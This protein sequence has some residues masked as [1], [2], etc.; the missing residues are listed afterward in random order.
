[1]KILFV[2]SNRLGDAVLSTGLLDH[3]IR[4][5][6]HCQ[7]TVVCGPV[8][9]GLFTHMP[10]REETIVLAKQPWGR[11][12]L[13][14]WMRVMET[15]WDL[16]IDIRGSAL[17][18]LLRT[19]QRAVFRG[20]KGPKVA[21]LGAML[22]LSPAPVPVVWLS[23]MDRRHMEIT[24]MTEQPIV[25]LAPTANWEPKV[26]PAERFAWFFHQ[27]GIQDALPVVVGGPGLAERTMAQQ[28]LEL[29]PEAMDLVGKLSLSEVVALLER[30]TL[31]VGNDSG[32]M[33][34][35]AATGTPTIGLFGPTDAATYGPTGR[36]ATAVIGPSMQAIHVHQVLE[37]A[38]WL[39]A[40]AR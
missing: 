1:M 33:H 25:V 17:A 40:D 26:W 9:E 27:L 24:L 2:T 6:P 4:T 20:G 23:G 37:A 5:N 35:A 18:Y 31:F 21:Q 28:L 38:Q 29:L 22:G 15:R 19:G 34:L 3:L 14:L 16:V 7:I 32:L 30:A 12:W 11:H 10:N 36:R 8:A 13:G 39:L